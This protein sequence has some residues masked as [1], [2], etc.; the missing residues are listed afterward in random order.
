MTI[1]LQILFIVLLIVLNG[2][3]AMSELAL[4]LARKV[5]LEIMAKNGQRSAEIALELA[6]HPNRFLS[7]VQ[8]GIT[9]V[10][11]CTGA[12]SG[13]TLHDEVSAWL[14]NTLPWLGAWSDPL[15]LI[16][17]IG[18][19][20]YLSL[21]GGELVPKQ[22]AVAHPEAIAIIVAL[23]MKM[24]LIIATPM[25]WLLEK[26]SNFFLYCLG[27]R[28]TA[29][30]GITE[31]EV[32]ALI[33]EGARVGVLKPAEKDMMAGVMRLADW[34]VRAFMTPRPNV[35]WINLAEDPATIKHKLRNSAYSRLPVAR[36]DLDE[37]IGIV[38][39]KDLLDQILDGRDLDISA[40]LREA[41]VVHGSS[42]AL[43]VLEVLRS[44]P[45]HFAMVAD[46][47]GQMQGIITATDIL[48]TIIGHLDNAP[49][50]AG[51][52]QRSDGSWLV[53]GN[54][55]FD[56]ATDLIGIKN[57]L[58]PTSDGNYATMAGFAL[59][60]LGHI[61]APGEH[62]IYENYYF[63]V[64][65]MDGRRIDKL[66]IAALSKQPPAKFDGS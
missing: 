65:N 6:R 49:S 33:A 51:V 41:V 23:P 63:E 35:E 40:V 46:D 10:G 39:A 36:N 45:L 58:L 21:I 19:V 53:D 32:R 14:T 2:F 5:R 66:L 24:L 30:E 16:L 20:G 22:I 52:V 57:L 7:T 43:G 18:S 13:A 15:A 26:S 31:D 54:L 64:V 34:R 8:V 42:P 60:R 47:Y 4:M 9:L 28:E 44:S 25:I 3:F 62:F 61:P 50:S 48:Q 59:A 55:A 27:Q 56:M 17:I 38:Q 11:I 37:L 29:A 1:S 12:F